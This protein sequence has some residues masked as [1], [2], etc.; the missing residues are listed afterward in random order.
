MT[1]IHDTHQ[2]ANHQ[3]L[4]HARHHVRSALSGLRAID[5]RELTASQHETLSR[6]AA[7]LADAADELGRLTT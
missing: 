2:P 5:V 3:Q 6:V 1:A 7:T 4:E